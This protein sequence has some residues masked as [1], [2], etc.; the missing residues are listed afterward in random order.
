MA[1]KKVVYGVFDWGL[2]HATRS[3][4]LIEELFKKDDMREQD[5]GRLPECVAEAQAGLPV[6]ITECG[7]AGEKNRPAGDR[8]Y[9]PRTHTHLAP[10]GNAVFARG[11][12]RQGFFLEGMWLN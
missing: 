3:K 8:L 7:G 10:G 11:R 6:Y 2:G 5:A 4:P 9:S 12:Q 1:G